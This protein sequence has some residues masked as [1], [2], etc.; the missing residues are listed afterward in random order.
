MA[1]ALLVDIG[2]TFLKGATLSLG[3]G[4]IIS[5]IRRPGPSL[6]LTKDGQATLSADHLRD[7]V[8]GLCRE[9]KAFGRGQLRG[10]FLTG[11]MHG[12]VLTDHHGI[13]VTD[14]ITW[15][16]H[17]MVS[18][19][20][21]IVSPVE[22]VRMRLD[23]TRLMAL[24][25]ELREGLPVCSL[26]ARRS[27]GL[28]TDGLTAHSLISYCA[29]ALIG[30]STSPKMHVTDAAAHGLFDVIN[31]CW[32]QT[33]LELLGLDRI[34]LPDVLYSVLPVGQSSEFD[35]DVFA[36]VGDQQAALLGMQLL[37]GEL[38]L[39]IAT[40]SQVSAISS[41][42]KRATQTRP[43]FD[44]RYVATFTHIPAGR[45]LN[46]LVE[47]VTELSSLTQDEAWAT[48]AKKVDR[49]ENV[50]LDIDLSY[51]PSLTGASGRISNIRE[52]DISVGQ[53]FKSAVYAMAK[54]Y[55]QFARKIFPDDQFN[56][57]VIS[58]GLAT[59]FPPLL[60][61]IKS[62]F[63]SRN[64]RISSNDDASLDGLRQISMQALRI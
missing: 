18:E 61:E 7:A 53:L 62:E 43:Y 42:P 57:V 45:A 12:V 4:Q 36:A 58:G 21:H 51:F 55:R 1:Y 24:G 47:L 32:D 2:G 35:C 19:Q 13:P 9:L 5:T 29:N 28:E 20:G 38:S 31:R 26:L 33:T 48:I 50:E 15:R 41:L 30:F 23:E 11:Q 40:G 59:R 8:I 17:L 52:G 37:E 10:I 34:V 25:N 64:Y 22:V 60:K 54:N 46:V 63:G 39:N 56:S 44:S 3:D 6:V 16:D 49:E 14:I 27:R